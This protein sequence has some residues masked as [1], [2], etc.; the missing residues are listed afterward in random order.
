MPYLAEPNFTSTATLGSDAPLS[1]AERAL[2][3][4][5]DEQFYIRCRRA[6]LRLNDQLA[7]AAEE[8]SEFAPFLLEAMRNAM[9]ELLEHG[10]QR[11]LLLLEQW[12]D[13]ENEPLTA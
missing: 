13:E 12:L 10:D 11:H 8:R 2:M 9:A 4:T 7:K 3:E 1:L 6:I 5:E